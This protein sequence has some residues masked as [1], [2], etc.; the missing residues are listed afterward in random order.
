M[1]ILHMKESFPQSLPLP[2]CRERAPGSADG[3]R[4]LAYALFACVLLACAYIAFLI[5]W[6]RSGTNTMGQLVSARYAT[7]TY[8]HA[9]YYSV[10][11]T[12]RTPEGLQTGWDKLDLVQYGSIE[13]RGL[14]APHDVKVCY[15]AIGPFHYAGLVE[16]D[17][18]GNRAGLPGFLL[19][20]LI[21]ISIQAAWRAWVVPARQRRICK[22]GP[23]VHSKSR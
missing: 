5:V 22:S 10:E 1:R 19:F 14:N 23:A 16:F 18:P 21:P 13:N 20:F 7:G 3:Q 8:R 6:A 15:L 11:F 9:G 12:Y 2:P 4:W 17:G